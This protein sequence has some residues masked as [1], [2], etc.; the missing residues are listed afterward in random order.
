MIRKENT[1]RE[2]DRR[3]YSALRTLSE[4]LRCTIRWTWI[5]RA[6]RAAAR[7]QFQEMQAAIS[8]GSI[9]A[10]RRYDVAPG[11]LEKIATEA[12]AEVSGGSA[13]AGLRFFWKPTQHENLEN[14]TGN[15]AELMG[16]S[17]LWCA[18]DDL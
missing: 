4:I 12:E 3:G 8:A 9:V 17:N 13:C 5:R 16:A 6:A 10:N 1:T 18:A 7:V 11:S 14:Y 15:A 2:R